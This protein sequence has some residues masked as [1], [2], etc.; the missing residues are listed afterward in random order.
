MAELIR[1]KGTISLH[2]CSAEKPHYYKKT[3]LSCQRR[4]NGGLLP[5][6]ANGRW[7]LIQRLKGLNWKMNHFIALCREFALENAVDP[8]KV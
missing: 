8:S 7:D 5:V 6:L 1:G 4:Q 2:G 3:L